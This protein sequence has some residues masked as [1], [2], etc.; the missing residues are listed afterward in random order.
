MPVGPAKHLFLGSVI[1]FI[2]NALWVL[3]QKNSSHAHASGFL[4]QELAEVF[5]TLQTPQHHF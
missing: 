3:L 4:P 2:L 5:V 1:P